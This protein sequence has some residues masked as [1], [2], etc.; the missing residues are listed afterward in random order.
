MSEV[1][2]PDRAAER[3]W[4][5]PGGFHDYL[6]RALKIVLPIGVG[7]LLA[8]LLLSPLSEKREVS[9]LLDK[10]KV[11]VARE[12]LK[13]Q[14]AQYR[15]SDNRGRPFVLNAD[16]AVQAKS[17]DPVVDIRGVS[18]QIDLPEG[19]ATFKADRGRYDMD[20]QNLD[21][22]G[23]ILLTAADGYRLHTRDVLVDLNSRS[24]KGENGVEGIMPLG[25]FTAQQMQADL[26]NR[27]V[28]LT[29]RARLHIVQGGLR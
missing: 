13:V 11:D 23:P 26:P 28:V 25:R 9:F 3:S 24:L 12:R 18:A 17:T 16:T 1:A 6:V 10:N 14:S 29:G 20:K 27:R 15:G 8:Y 7:V 5:R 4:A 2:R 21:V 22:I 19:P